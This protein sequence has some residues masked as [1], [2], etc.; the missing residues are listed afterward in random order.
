MQAVVIHQFGGDQATESG[1][2]PYPRTESRRGID[3]RQGCFDQSQRRQKCRRQNARHGITAASPAAT[4]PGSSSGGA[5]DLIGREVWGT[6]GDISRT[7]DGSHAQYLLLPRAAVTPKPA[8]LSMEAAATAGL[9][10]ITAWQ[11]I[12]AVGRS[13]NRVKRWW[14]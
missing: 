10:F 5:G 14:S 9:S 1:R 7:R 11:A 4:T 2:S 6:G 12:V 3:C 8:A 13:R